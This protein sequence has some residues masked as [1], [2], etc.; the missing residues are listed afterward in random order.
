MVAVRLWGSLG[1]L[2]GAPEVEI[3]ATTLRELLQG[4]EAEYPALAPQLARGVSVSIDGRIYNDLWA[5]PIREDS[6]VVLLNRLVG[7]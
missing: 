6:E 3:A 7:G 2:A 4:L 5:T 1:E